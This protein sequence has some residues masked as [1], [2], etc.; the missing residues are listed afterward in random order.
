MKSALN[1]QIQKTGRQP[2]DTKISQIRSEESY[3]EQYSQLSQWE[4]ENLNEPQFKAI[5][6]LLEREIRFMSE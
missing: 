1:K 6:E 4:K 5:K 3:F 2:I